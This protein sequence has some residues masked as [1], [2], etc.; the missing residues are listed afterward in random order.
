MRL[1]QGL[2]AVS[3]ASLIL[4][5]L[6]CAV[7]LLGHKNEVE[8]NVGFGLTSLALG[9][10]LGGVG[11]LLLA[12]RRGN[13]LGPLLAMAG[14]SLVLEFSLR[15][16]SYR[17]LPYA[18]WAL[19]GGLGLDPFFFPISI[20]LV[21]FFFPDV[22]PVGRWRALLIVGLTVIAVQVAVHA[23]RAGPLVDEAF[24][25][26]AAWRG[27]LPVGMPADVILDT[28]LLVG[29]VLLAASVITLLAR[30]ARADPE[31]RQ[32]LKPLALVGTT[33]VGL[34]L[35]QQVPALR[36]TATTGF[37]I[38]IAAGFPAALAVGA[39]RYRVWDFDPILV[40]AIVYGALA[41]SVTTIY[42]VVVVGLSTLSGSQLQGNVAVSVAA[43]ALVAISFG[44]LKERITR[45]ARHFVYG[46]RASPYEAL[47]ALPHRLAE[48]PAVD[49]VLSSTADA[50]ANGLGVAVA[51]VRAFVGLTRMEAWSPAPL[52]SPDGLTTVE[53]RHLGEVVGDVA[54]QTWPDRVLSAADHR[55][56]TD[57]AAQAGPALRSVALAAELEAR[58][59]D[60]RTSRHRLV[61]AQVQERHRLERD[62][63]DGAQQQLV[64][65]AVALESAE[66]SLDKDPAAAHQAL[67]DA[68]RQAQDCIDDLRELA[69]GLYP[70]VLAASGLLAA[71]RARARTGRVRVAEPS[72]VD[73][74]R[75]HADIELAVY[76]ACLE[77]MQN[78]AK[79][80]PG[81]RTQLELDYRDGTLAFAVHD[82]G[83]GFDAR[84]VAEQGT[85][86]VALA[87]R[88]GAVGGAVAVESQ[89]G[90][91]TT[92]RGTIAA[93][94]SGV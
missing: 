21:L 46:V 2:A 91:G 73:G 77:A 11:W 55:L 84:T 70:P 1:R 90:G 34:L 13:V 76:F 30:Y 4:L 68:R 35:L 69:R 18:D 94:P 14:G 93:S 74:L 60:L 50:L 86:L 19:W 33:T 8:V 48:V 54:V 40:K 29:V 17:G 79:H 89:P 56:L 72:T 25:Y 26:E 10:A 37:V 49:Q 7:A 51:R 80:A 53:I 5:A 65:L 38:A 47:A 59:V 32:R 6:V 92:V 28:L 57:L 36:T 67:R 85:G 15:E 64:A 58:L 61:L 3:A 83:P 16:Y 39:L 31:G 23:L 42:V 62:I 22:R 24:G 52:P 82:D 12:T 20:A 71:L 88:I 45:A 43:T 87:D 66:R 81:A 44:P 78:A 75:F 63:H 27:T 9:A 41:A